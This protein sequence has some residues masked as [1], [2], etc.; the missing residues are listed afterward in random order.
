MKN[1][2]VLRDNP[3]QLFH[4]EKHILTF[5][6]VKWYHLAL[7]QCEAV[8]AA[9]STMSPAYNLTAKCE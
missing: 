6:W 2:E 8:D 3:S 5:T 7:Y 1:G 4:I 9:G